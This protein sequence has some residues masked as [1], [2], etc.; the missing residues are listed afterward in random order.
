MNRIQ[1]AVSGGFDA[2]GGE[3][4]STRSKGSFSPS[5]AIRMSALKITVG[6][7]RPSLMFGT[8]PSPALRLEDIV[9]HIVRSGRY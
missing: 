2:I 8:R 1:Q 3:E 6:P 4:I 5:N 7:S 9:E